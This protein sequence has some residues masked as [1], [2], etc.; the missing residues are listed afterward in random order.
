MAA[1]ADGPPDG[2]V[3]DEASRTGRAP[4]GESRRERAPGEASRRARAPD[5]V[6]SGAGPG[7][8]VAVMTGFARTLRAAGVPADHERTQ[9]MLRALAHL[10]AS[11]PGD[12]YWAGRFTL[13][14][15][16]DDLP[17]YDRVFRAYFG[18]LRA[19]RTTPPAITVTRHTTVLS[20]APGGGDEAPALAATASAVEVLRTRDVA[21]MTAPEL[22]EA[23]R[24]LALMRVGRRQRRSRRFR[25]ARRGRLDGRATIRETLRRGG[26]TA[27]LRYRAHRTR[28]RR[29]VLLVDVSGSMSPY[30]DT[31]LR[32]AHALVR[33]EPRATEVFSAGTRLTRITAELRHRD[34]STAM[35]AVFR[36]IPDWSGGTRLGEE[37]RRFLARGD[38]G[39]AIVVIAS[40]GWERGDASLLGAQMARLSRTA[41]RVIWVNPHKGQQ[42]YQPLTAGMR[43]ALPYVDDFVAGHSLAAFEELAGLLGGGNA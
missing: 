19:G 31:L 1:A 6:P 32:L 11:R 24:L 15:S 16:A 39:G 28:P 5:R 17:R 10:D 41:H 20:G 38:A 25:A 21:A 29:V 27:G 2:G 30:A 37:L 34:P 3:P 18:G 43:A 23:H 42:G 9:S 4:G 40:D 13:C 26:E 33:S 7:D 14:A 35:S 36:A 8:L 12:V 22:A